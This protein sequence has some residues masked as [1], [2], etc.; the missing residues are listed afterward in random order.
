MVDTFGK[1]IIGAYTEGTPVKQ[2]RSYRELVWPERDIPEGYERYDYIHSYQDS[3]TTPAAFVFHDIPWGA[4]SSIEAKFDLENTQYP[5]NWLFSYSGGRIEE[6]GYSAVA[7]DIARVYNTDRSLVKLYRTEMY[8]PS[9]GGYT[10]EASDVVDNPVI[11]KLT[12]TDFY[13]NG[14]HVHQWTRVTGY[15]SIHLSIF[16][17]WNYQQ[18]NWDFYQGVGS[19]NR[20]YWLKVKAGDV[21]LYKFV[22]AVRLSDGVKGLW[23]EVN[24][25]FYIKDSETQYPLY[26]GND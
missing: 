6:Q 9:E 2:I 20:L 15:N 11:I 1:D 12:P 8:S 24:E 25:V 4:N 17:Y 3:D 10:S 16:G 19:T 21:V 26:V 18:G 5:G 23:D 7:K 13:L 22:P 14:K